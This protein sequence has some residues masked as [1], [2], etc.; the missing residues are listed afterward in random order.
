MRKSVKQECVK[1][2]LIGFRNG[3]L[4]E[5]P[6]AASAFNFA[7]RF[8]ASPSSPSRVTF[9]GPFFGSHNFCS[10][11][12][13]GSR[14]NDKEK[15]STSVECVKSSSTNTNAAFERRRQRYL[16]K[17]ACPG[18]GVYM[19]DTDPKRPGYFKMPANFGKSDDEFEENV[20]GGMEEDESEEFSDDDD[21]E[22]SGRA[23]LD[24]SDFTLDEDEEDMDMD[25][26]LKNATEWNEI[27]GNKLAGKDAWAEILGGKNWR[28]KDGAQGEAEEEE[29][30]VVC[31]RCHALRNY[32]KVKDE[33]VENLLPDFDFERV[34][35]ARLKKAYGRRAVVLMV[36]DGSDFDG[37]FPRKAAEVL[38]EADEELGTAWQEGK[39][40]NTPRLLVVMNKIDLLPKQISANRLEQWVRRRSKAGGVTRIAG[41]HTVS[42][43]KGWGIEQ[44]AD[45][46]KQL[47]G[48]R[49]DCWVVGAQ[50]AGK[51]SL[52]NSL[53]KFAG[54]KRRVT[55]LTEA[56]VPGTTLG[57]LKLEGILPARARLFDTPGL[58]H[59][60]QL[61]TKLNREELKLVEVRKEL[62]PRTF[63]VK[64][65]S[66]VHV[67]GL[68][69]LDVMEAPSESIYVTV[70]ASALL[71]CHMGKTEKAE[72][73]FEKHLGDRLAPPVDKERAAEI[74]RWVARRVTV[75]GDS[76]EHSSVDVA[77]AGLGWVGIGVKGIAVLQAWTYEGVQ[78][79][80]H[81][82]MVFDMAAIFEKPG[83]TAMKSPNKGDK[84]SK[85]QKSKPKQTKPMEEMV[86]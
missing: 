42:A 78:V 6:I 56:A 55:A 19:Q 82:A 79:T 53:A 30:V 4:T 66:T 83:F 80:T 28:K 2:C 62:K 49:G 26:R 25:T 61:S 14:F 44:L 63:R 58:I 77:V 76:W 48:P 16:E 51:S 57:V 73:L 45:H 8:W 11:S 33:S 69:R 23:E 43:F 21:E 68:L 10:S 60:H 52:I 12:S 5:R 64:V 13:S 36:V 32:G 24:E 39:S 31:A 72:E 54:E 17:L 9:D 67:A 41:V 7:N 18:C 81:E 46:I 84:K 85:G 70:W 37:S 38:A 86:F 3:K 34:V 50:N 1:Y 40:G 74:G 59:P 75:T 65:G 35:G 27:G 29:K 15:H 22:F 71:S 20:V 47:A